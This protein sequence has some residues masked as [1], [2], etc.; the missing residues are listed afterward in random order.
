MFPFVN[1][2]I[3][4]VNCLES[5]WQHGANIHLRQ[6]DR[7]RN[8]FCERKFKELIQRAI[9]YTQSLS[10]REHIL[11]YG[12]LGSGAGLYES[13]PQLSGVEQLVCSTQYY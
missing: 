13:L 8:L 2:T 1:N 3:P 5:V 6:G 9:T 12:Q 4:C 10:S 11:V 7:N